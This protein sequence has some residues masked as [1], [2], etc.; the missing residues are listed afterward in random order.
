MIE[1]I[2][3]PLNVWGRQLAAQARRADD[4]SKP[5]CDPHGLG[6]VYVLPPLKSVT[7]WP[8]IRGK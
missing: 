1:D 7:S 3:N 8:L 6:T 4:P 5:A 2:G